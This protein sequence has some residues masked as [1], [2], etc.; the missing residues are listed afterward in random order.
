MR[1]FIA[2]V[3]CYTYTNVTYT[4]LH[5]YTTICVCIHVHI[6]TFLHLCYTDYTPKHYIYTYGRT[7]RWMDVCAAMSALY[8]ICTHNRS[9]RCRCPQHP[10]GRKCLTSPQL[11][12]LVNSC[13]APQRTTSR[14]PSTCHNAAVV[15]FVKFHHAFTFPVC[16]LCRPRV[17]RRG[18]DDRSIH[19]IPPRSTR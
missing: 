4:V 19:Q 11:P 6:S 9:I 14:R 10:R 3:Q 2:Y 13:V 16:F 1:T 17:R 5:R 15:K 12:N 18:N 7:Y 8:N